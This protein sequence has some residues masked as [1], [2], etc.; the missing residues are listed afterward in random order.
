MNLN[1]DSYL[2][3]EVHVVAISK[4][5]PHQVVNP[6]NVICIIRALLAFVAVGLLIEDGS[7]LIVCT[8]V[9][10]SVILDAVDGIVARWFG[11]DGE[12]GALTDIYTDHI[13][14][15]ALWVLFAVVGVIPIWVPLLTTTRDMVVDYCRQVTAVVT[16]QNGFQ[17][18]GCSRLRWIVSSRFMRAFYA[19]CKLVSW[20][21]LVIAPLVAST[22]L[23]TFLMYLVWF[24]CFLCIIRA[25]PAMSVSWRYV[26]FAEEPVRD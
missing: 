19:G 15:N 18:V 9:F 6:A 26:I 7:R 3:K 2:I 25:L 4:R 8:L 22:Y 10:T 23:D 20:C 1:K 13:I 24:T 21:L 11:F 17:Q 5:T 12:V 14:A 16:G